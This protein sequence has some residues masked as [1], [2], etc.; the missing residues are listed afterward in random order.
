MRSSA[1]YIWWFVVLTFVIVFVFAETSGLT[2]RGALT[3]GSTVASVNGTEIT[4]DSWLRARESRI[5]Q[6][7]QQSA[8]P[9]TLDQEQRVED[10]T[11]DDLV[12]DILLRQ[13]YERR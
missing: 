1:K 10:A 7:Q 11:F 2:G 3:R 4:Y 13:E 9:L 8:A 12:N 5:Q 6:A